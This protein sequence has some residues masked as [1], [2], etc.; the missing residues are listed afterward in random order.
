MPFVYN[1][2]YVPQCLVW[3]VYDMSTA[4]KLV[5]ATCS[6]T[7]QRNTISTWMCASIARKVVC[8]ANDMGVQGFKAKQYEHAFTLYTEA[9]RLCPRKAAYHCNRAAAA[10]KLQQYA[11]AAED[12]RY[13]CHPAQ[14]KLQ[15]AQRPPAHCLLECYWLKASQIAA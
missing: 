6:L 2:E 14:Y 4:V 7:V 11:I 5:P 10:L 12:T 1:S 15:S 9:I 13:A 8:R 3:L